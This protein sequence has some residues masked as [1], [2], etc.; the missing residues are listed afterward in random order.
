[1]PRDLTRLAHQCLN[2]MTTRRAPFRTVRA[3][4]DVGVG[5]NA[6]L[7][8]DVTGARAELGSCGFTF[9]ED[10]DP[11]TGRPYLL[12]RS[13]SPTGCCPGEL[14]LVDRSSTPA[15]CLGVPQAA[16]DETCVD[17]ALRLWRAV[18]GSLLHLSTAPRDDTLGP[19]TRGI[20]QLQIVRFDGRAPRGPAGWAAWGHTADVVVSVGS[21]DVTLPALRIAEHVQAIGQ[22]V[23]RGWD[24]TET[25]KPSGWADVQ[26]LNARRRHGVWVVLAVGPRVHS[27]PALWQALA[28][29]V[30]EADPARFVPVDLGA[31]S[32]GRSVIDSSLGD[33]FLLRLESDTLL[34]LTGEPAP[35]PRILLHLEAPHEARTL[36]MW[37]TPDSPGSGSGT[38]LGAVT[39]VPGRSWYGEI[40][41]DGGRWF[42]VQSFETPDPAVRPRP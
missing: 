5:L 35:E 16:A 18:P 41:R 29:T 20:A 42:L 34:E 14:L 1:M 19:G 2:D 12:A 38:G 22:D 37:A 26:S 10:S 21:A 24:G 9:V 36:R 31:T 6:L 40:C 30:A 7:D 13:G 32:G 23:R 28:D 17:L 33:H 11:V 4:A 3:A 15:L 27:T 39:V 25:E 8:G